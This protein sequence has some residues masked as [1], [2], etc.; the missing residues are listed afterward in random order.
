MTLV[1]ERLFLMEKFTLSFRNVI[2][3]RFYKWTIQQLL[4]IDFFFSNLPRQELWEWSAILGRKFYHWHYLE[5]INIV[6]IKS[7]LK[8]AGLWLLLNGLQ[9]ML[10]SHPTMVAY[11][12]EPSY[13]TPLACCCAT[14]KH[15]WIS[16]CMSKNVTG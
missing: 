8:S 10:P 16:K 9:T 5:L 13:L 12:L 14:P 6:I 4:F 1:Y 11:S 2:Q 15:V 7:K 3:I